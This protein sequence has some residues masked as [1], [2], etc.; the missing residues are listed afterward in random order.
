[1]KQAPPTNIWGGFDFSR[2]EPLNS[3]D[4]LKVPVGFDLFTVPSHVAGAEIT[5]LH[6]GG[7]PRGLWFAKVAWLPIISAGGP[8]EILAASTE[9]SFSHA[10][11]P[12]PTPTFDTTVRN[13]GIRYVTYGSLSDPMP[14]SIKLAPSQVFGIRIIS[15]N[16]TA[17]TP[18]MVYV[19]AMGHYFRS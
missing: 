19:R 9:P 3:D 1:M 8:Q 7:E 14:V 13:A 5:R 17:G 16:A 6:V 11:D 4:T 18:F 12:I 15:V 2:C 10:G